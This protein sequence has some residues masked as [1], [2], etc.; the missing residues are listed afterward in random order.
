MSVT[1]YEGNSGRIVVDSLNI[2][3]KNGGTPR[4]TASNG[5]S[6]EGIRVPYQ[7]TSVTRTLGISESNSVITNEPAGGPL[8]LTLPDTTEAGVVFKFVRIAAFAF[9]IDPPTGSS[10]I[11][12]GGTM[13]TGEYLELASNGAKLHLVSDGSG[14]WVATYEF[15]TLTQETP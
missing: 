8:T 12:S 2:V 9:R 11:Y 5:F 7:A 6:L 14:N 15:G 13:S 4:L 10:I 1:I 3:A